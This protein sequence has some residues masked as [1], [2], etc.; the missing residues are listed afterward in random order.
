LRTGMRTGSLV[1]G[2]LSLNGIGGEKLFPS[3]WWQ[4]IS[5]LEEAAGLHDRDDGDGVQASEANRKERDLQSDLQS[6]V[7]LFANT[8]LGDKMDTLTNFASAAL[9]LKRG[10]ADEDAPD[11]DTVATVAKLQNLGATVGIAAPPQLLSVVSEVQMRAASGTLMEDAEALKAEGEEKLKRQAVGM[12][13]SKAQQF[14]QSMQDQGGGRLQMISSVS[15]ASPSVKTALE[16]LQEQLSSG[17]VSKE[18]VMSVL[19]QGKESVTSEIEEAKAVAIGAIAGGDGGNPVDWLKLTASRIGEEQMAR[20]RERLLSEIEPA[21]R[22]GAEENPHPS[23][24]VVH[25]VV[26]SLLDAST[27]MALQMAA[28]TAARASP[29]INTEG[30]DEDASVAVEAQEASLGLQENVVVPLLNAIDEEVARRTQ[31]LVAEQERLKAA[32]AAAEARAEQVQ[33][34]AQLEQGA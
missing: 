15:S 19:R 24:P 9:D 1:D 11:D 27:G 25:S 32:L 31:E 28:M 13:Q 14:S 3:E 5:A 6:A 16:Q 17:E 22:T 23:A 18:R 2:F 21:M 4:S 30:V 7:Q 34:Q 29:G 26:E 20:V 8:M 10:Q 12:V 33:A